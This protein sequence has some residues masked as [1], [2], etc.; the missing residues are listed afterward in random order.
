MM[1]SVVR[2]AGLIGAG[3]GFAAAAFTTSATAGFA[4]GEGFVDV[5]VVDARGGPDFGLAAVL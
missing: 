4:G 5:L 2:R 3:C 1:W